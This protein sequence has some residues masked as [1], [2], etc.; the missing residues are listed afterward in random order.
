MHNNLQSSCLHFEAQCALLQLVSTFSHTFSNK[1]L[2]NHPTKATHRSSLPELKNLV[3]SGT[4]RIRT[5]G[6]PGARWKFSAFPS[7]FCR[8]YNSFNFPWPESG[9]RSMTMYSK[10]VKI[11]FRGVKL[12]PRFESYIVYIKDKER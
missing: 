8:N 12:C 4:V 5:Y 11:V 10:Y 2:T 6:T 3:K 9:G 1:R 7:Y